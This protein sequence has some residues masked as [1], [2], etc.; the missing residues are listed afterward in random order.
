MRLSDQ[1]G[2]EGHAHD[3]RAALALRVQH[4]ELVD[5]HLRVLVGRVEVGLQDDDVVEVE[6]VGHADQPPERTRTGNGWSSWKRSH[7]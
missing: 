5:D 4:V 7:V 3:A 6:R 1:V 2:V